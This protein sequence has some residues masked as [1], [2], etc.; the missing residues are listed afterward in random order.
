MGFKTVGGPA[1]KTMRWVNLRLRETVMHNLSTP[2]V[3]KSEIP[4]NH[5]KG[6][7]VPRRQGTL[8]EIDIRRSH[9][10]PRAV[11]LSS[12]GRIKIK[13][14]DLPYDEKDKLLFEVFDMLLRGETNPDP[15][16][17]DRLSQ[18]RR[19]AD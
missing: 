12:I 7:T 4:S 10:S 8:G 3:G 5:V 16:P 17:R 2:V 11:K 9:K 14:T 6:R 18:T 15:I 13:T 1:G 19:N